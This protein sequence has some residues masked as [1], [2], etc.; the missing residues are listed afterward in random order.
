M[1]TISLTLGDAPVAVSATCAG[2]GILVVIDLGSTQPD[3]GVAGNLRCDAGGA[4]GRV[5]LSESLTGDVTVSA[6][7]VEGG[8]ATQHAA[9]E[10]S[11]EQPSGT[12]SE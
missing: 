1:T 11:I 9:Y 10:I 3:V 4:T 6:F 12:A 2:R 8:G 7:V 5:E